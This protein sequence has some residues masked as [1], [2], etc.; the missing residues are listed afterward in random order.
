MLKSYI[1]SLYKHLDY[2]LCIMNYEL[3]GQLL[4]ATCVIKVEEDNFDGRG[5]TLRYC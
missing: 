4:S 3:Y 2:E 1:I 5:K